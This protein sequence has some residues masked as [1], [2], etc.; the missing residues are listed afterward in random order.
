MDQ[1]RRS[2]VYIGFAWLAAIAAGVNLYWTVDD[3]PLVPAMRSHKD[4]SVFWNIVAGGSLLAFFAMLAGGVPLVLAMLRFAKTAGRR[5]ILARLLFPPLGGM[6][7]FAWFG[8]VL[9]WTGGHW[10]PMPWAIVGDGP[11]WP[12]LTN[13]WILGTMTLVLL[14]ITLAG[15]A[16]CFAQLMRRTE[17]GKEPL[18]FLGKMLKIGPLQLARLPAVVLAGAIVVMAAAVFGWGF[19]A[20][21]Y[22]TGDFHE[23]GGGVL[24]T[25]TFSSWMLSLALFVAAALTA[26]RGARSILAAPA[27]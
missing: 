16:I 11:G 19:L 8:A 21:Q 27:E 7:V 10:A 22:A 1:L 5:D 2:L 3:S 18:V 15:S 4:L 20:N 6:V 26:I 14:G 12:D 24:A 13:R 9:V 25:T 17:F 23:H